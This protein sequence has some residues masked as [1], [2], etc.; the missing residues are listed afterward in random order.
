M[1]PQTALAEFATA[2]QQIDGLPVQYG[3]Y[4]IKARLRTLPGGDQVLEASR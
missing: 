1:N 4:I 3:R 2:V